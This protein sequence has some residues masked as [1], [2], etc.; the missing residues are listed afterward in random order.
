MWD[1]IKAHSLQVAKVAL[2]IGQGIWKKGE[3]ISLPLVLA[4]ALLHDIGKTEALRKGGDHVEIGKTI[5]VEQGLK[6]VAQIVA[7]H[8][9]LRSFC[10]NGVV[11]EKEIVYYADKRVN[12]D[13]IVSLE[14]RLDYILSRY[15]RKDPRL[16][17]AI[18]KNF[19]MCKE[20]EKKLFT[21]LDFHPWE[22]RKL[23][24]KQSILVK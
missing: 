12:H 16:R 23:A 2:L 21:Y 3:D 11:Q 4:G 1:N 14:E 17:Q 13:Q 7:E 24:L 9:R 18:V 10:S 8:V 22:V 20:V 6:E 19:H 5:C 15:A